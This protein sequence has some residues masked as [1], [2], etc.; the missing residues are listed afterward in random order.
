LMRFEK[1]N[2]VEIS[3]NRSLLKLYFLFIE[4]SLTGSMAPQQTLFLT[5]TQLMFHRNDEYSTIKS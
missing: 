3:Y 1:K 5:V 4:A 2:Y